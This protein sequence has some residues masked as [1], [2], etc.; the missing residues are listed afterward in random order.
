MLRI[1]GGASGGGNKRP[2]TLP[3]TDFS[4]K[5]G[6]PSEVMDALRMT[7]P[8]LKAFLE[9]PTAEDA[10]QYV[11]EQKNGERIQSRMCAV[12]AEYEKVKDSKQIIS[13]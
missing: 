5:P 12:L 9:L 3:V 7:V 13:L 2:R 4:V 1:T 11:M 10:V 6:D 8:S